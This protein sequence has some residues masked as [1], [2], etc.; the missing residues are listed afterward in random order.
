MATATC[1]PAGG[2]TLD[3]AVA[4]KAGPRVEH[5]IAHANA[6]V[7][8]PS[9]LLGRVFDKKRQKVSNTLVQ[10]A[11][12]KR[13][14]SGFESASDQVFEPQQKRSEPVTAQHAA[15]AISKGPL[16]CLA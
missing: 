10:K 7:L 11:T 8:H 13:L 14:C 9:H 6:L 4:G 15:E 16:N 1:H 12:S 2:T 5:P 3:A